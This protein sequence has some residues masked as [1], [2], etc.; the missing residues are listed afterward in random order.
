MR[1]S[2]TTAYIHLLVIIL[3]TSACACSF[4]SNMSNRELDDAGQRISFEYRMFQRGK[5]GSSPVSLDKS[6]GMLTL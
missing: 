6:G 3:A 1:Y 4:G 2:R 5:H